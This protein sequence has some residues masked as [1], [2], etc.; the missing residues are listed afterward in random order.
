MAV[1]PNRLREVRRIG[2]FRPSAVGDFA[3]SLPALHALR[4]A[5]RDAELV[6]LGQP[7]HADFLDQRPGPVDRVVVVPP[8]P[9]I[10]LPPSAGG[11]T[12]RIGEFISQMRDECFDLALQM[13]GGGRFA[14]G[15]LGQL[16]ARTTAGMRTPDAA[17][18]D[19]SLPY[20]NFV[21]RRLQLL[22]VAAL[23]GAAPW[24][25]PAPLQVTGADREQAA[26]LL[27]LDERRPLV[28]LQP[29]A[30][31]VRRRW[32]AAR[33][34]ALADALAQEGATIAIN[35][36]EDERCLAAS[37]TDAMR[38]D[39]VDLSGRASLGA[40]CGVLERAALVVS[41]DTGP[42]HLAL[43]LNRPCVGI[44]WL[45]NLVESAP[46]QQQWHRAAVS[47]RTACPVCGADNV[48][49]RCPHEVSFVADVSFADVAALA[50][51][52]YRNSC[53]HL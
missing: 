31:D 22:E 3:F 35:G 44:Y 33:F 50:I 52:L 51:D 15:L 36:S 11:D 5:Y 25:A 37:V 40:L 6:Y 28:V 24:F 41:N 2:V 34:A 8:I 16:G 4:T 39:A 32:P 18:L 19:R 30:S 12:A 17:P 10:T 43:A 13:Y 46:L 27:P 53:T 20:T 9:G 42:L 47:L 23:A 1:N 29:G 26:R 7:W 48:T 14:N 49:A 38:H 21:N 45:S